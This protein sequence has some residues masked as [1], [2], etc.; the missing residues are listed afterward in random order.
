MNQTT[1]TST[2]KTTLPNFSQVLLEISSN[3]CDKN[4]KK[5]ELKKPELFGSWFEADHDF[6]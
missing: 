4:I 3:F 6:D 5:D 1:V 2:A